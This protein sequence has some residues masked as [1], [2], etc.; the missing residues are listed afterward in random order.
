[1]LSTVLPCGVEIHPPEERAAILLSHYAALPLVG[2]RHSGAFKAQNR[3]AP[4][5]EVPEIG[6]AW[7]GHHNHFASPTGKESI[8]QA[9]LL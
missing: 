5:P 4:C 9:G 3:F 7:S 8:C 2:D 6:R 1:M